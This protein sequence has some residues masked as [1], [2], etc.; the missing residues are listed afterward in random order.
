MTSI[1]PEAQLQAYVL[2]LVRDALSHE[3][4]ESFRVEKWLKLRLGRGTHEEDGT[5]YWKADGRAD[6]VVY[7]GVRPLAVF[8]LKREDHP[9]TVD[10]VDQ[11][12]S[13]ATVM[14]ERPPLVI[15]SNGN[16]TWLR[17]ASDGQ[18][19]DE[20]LEGIGFVE[21]LFA[22]IGK[23]AASNNGWAIEV[24]MGPEAKVWIEAVRRR[25][26]ELIGRLT[27]DPHDTRKPFARDVLF[28]RSA[29]AEI[30]SLLD[31]GAKAIFVE[32]PP[33]VGKSNVLRQLALECRNSPNWAVL[34]V[35]AAT[36]GPGLF[37]R[38]ANI[39]GEALE[40]KLTADDV[41]TWLRRMSRSSRRPSLLLAVDG[42]RPGSDVASDLEELAELG[43]GEGLRIVVTTD[44]ADD[45]LLDTR[46]RGESAL[47]PIAEVI[48][49][50]RL[51][52]EEFQQVREA[53][54]PDRILFYGGAELS[55]EYRA[56][57]ILRS[58]LA[59]GHAPDDEGQAA[60]IPATIGLRTIRLAR[61][62]LSKLGEVARLHR[63][64]ARDALADNEAPDPELALSQANAYVIR[65]DALS[66]AGEA[67]AAKLEELGWISFHR[68]STGE[69]VVV[70]RAPEFLMSELASELAMILDNLIDEDVEDAAIQLIWQSER[71][72]LGDLVGAQAMVDLATRRKTLPVGLIEPL[73][74]DPPEPE[75]MAGKLIGIASESGEI[76]NL[77]FDEN[78]GVARA[79]AQGNPIEP[80]EPLGDEDEAPMM[81]GNMTSWMILSQLARLRAAFGS[82]S[83]ERFDVEIILHVGRCTM[84]LIRG[85][86]DP[87]MAHATQRLGAAGT[88][89]ALPQALAE[90]ITAAIHRLV[91]EEWR[92][93]VPF[94]EKLEKADSLPL[95]ARVHNALASLRGS[96]DTELDAFAETMLRTIV[97]PL[98]RKQ[99]AARA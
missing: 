63:L 20:G 7:H 99:I 58:V 65:R 76:V 70:F 45:L 29:T 74:N 83:G 80:F 87:T 23:L 82:S 32:G 69:D 36:H 90:P 16:E 55:Q 41:R 37:Q 24:L 11:A 86:I 57:W 62:R 75:S 48:A 43:F 19:L 95:T 3:P 40:W 38:L 30:L 2:G 33:L 42:L 22:N 64:V 34:M 94:F 98:L 27:G 96:V 10:D 66:S 35:N 17:Q 39:L 13:Y 89:L 79:D 52:G 73:M 88:V 31:A 5:K 6:L 9:L 28:R 71:F 26:D 46:G 49:V 25:T 50:G 54:A 44:R 14:I 8:E 92:D 91:A 1:I 51:D 68:H 4:P 97:N 53:L 84:P 72:F 21:K 61:A 93:L 47:A 59:D 81:Y 67:A 12:R 77:R 85:G 56:A 78:G 18:P 60:V 15:V